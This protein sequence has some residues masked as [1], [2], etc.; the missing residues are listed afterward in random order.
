MRKKL[1]KAQKAR[2]KSNYKAIRKEY[3]KVKNNIEN[4]D[5]N[6]K[7]IVSY[8]QFKT[9]TMNKAK[10][11]N[12]SIKEAAKKEAN[13]ESFINAGERSRE[14]LLSA[15]K[16]KHRESYDELRNLSRNKGKFAKLNLAWDK[17]RRGYVLNADGKQ[18]FIDVSNSPE[19]VNITEIN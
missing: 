3:N 4:I 14:N 9:R 17:S 10:K 5:E 2:N 8:K 19:E 11:D 7:L 6:G 1:T 12:I 13:T 15:L 18:Y 16:T